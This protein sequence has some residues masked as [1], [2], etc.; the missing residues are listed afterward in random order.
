M[1]RRSILCSALKKTS[2][3]TSSPP[4]YQQG[5]GNNIKEEIECRH[6]RREKAL[7]NA[8]SGQDDFHKD[9]HD[10]LHLD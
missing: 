10:M 9:G 8:V 2:T 1:L 6:Q 5:S 3:S 4:Y 7:L